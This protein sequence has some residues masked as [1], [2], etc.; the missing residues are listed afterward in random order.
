MVN[1]AAATH[2]CFLVFIGAGWLEKD[3]VCNNIL[4][5]SI[6]QCIAHL[7]ASSDEV[8]G[9][10]SS[11]PPSTLNKCFSSIRFLDGSK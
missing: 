6:K 4:D 11:S 3:D 2:N 9:C 8:I 5:R 10:I 7:T 1:L